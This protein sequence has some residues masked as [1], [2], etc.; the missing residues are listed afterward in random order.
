MAANAHTPN[1]AVHDARLKHS[2]NL[3]VKHRWG[4]LHD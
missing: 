1:N 3:I 4:V 2:S